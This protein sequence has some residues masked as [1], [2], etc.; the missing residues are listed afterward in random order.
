MSLYIKTH[1]NGLREL[2]ANNG[3]SILVNGELFH[4]LFIPKGKSVDDYEAIQNSDYEPPVIE[5][6]DE[7]TKFEGLRTNQIEISKKNLADYLGDN[8]L[9]S[10]AKY[11]DGEYY[12][13]TQEKQ[14]MLTD[15]LLKYAM[16]N[17]NAKNSYTLY[18]N[19]TGKPSEVWSYEELLRLSKD[20]EGYV[21]PLVELQQQVELEI[22]KCETVDQILSIN[23]NPY[24]ERGEL[25]YEANTLN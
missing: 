17:V 2:I 11:E 16:F 24:R 23:V 14:L 3:Y 10:Y 13:V 25:Y 18:W 4:S 8:P 5:I 19:A 7:K 1:D 21:R 20:I 12:T 9:L 6:E 15:R 22:N